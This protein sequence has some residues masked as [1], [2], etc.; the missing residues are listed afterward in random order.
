[1]GEQVKRR[2][3]PRITH[4]AAGAMLSRERFYGGTANS[5][6]ASIKNNPRHK[7]RPITLATRA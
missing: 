6:L 5:A 3:Q 2:R 4:K 7:R 1:M